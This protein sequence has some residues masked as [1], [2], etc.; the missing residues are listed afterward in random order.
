MKPFRLLACVVVV[1]MMGSILTGCGHKEHDGH[2]HNHSHGTEG[3]AHGHGHEHEQNEGTSATFKPGEGVRLSEE[4][5]K[6]LGV[7]IAAVTERKL[8]MEIQF[9]AQVFG[10]DHKATAAETYHAECTAKATG[11]IAQEKAGPV[12]PGTPLQL[13]TKS[14]EPLSGVVLGVTKALAIGDVEVIMG[15]TNAAAQLTSGD[16]LS[17][18]ITIP[19]EQPAWVVPSAAV[20]RSAQG[21]FVYVVKG[22]AYFRTAVKTGVEAEGMVEISD[23]VA[24]FKPPEARNAA[25]EKL[26]LIE[27]RATRGG[28]H[29]H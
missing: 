12:R 15:I 7:E 29:S 18:A 21:S 8:P 2:S 27:L 6:N 5:R 11:L 14:G 3:E 28:G 16:F 17:V 24:A 13:R 23:G 22:E 9:T 4:T 10:E 1:G 19:R 26:W 20:L 25:V